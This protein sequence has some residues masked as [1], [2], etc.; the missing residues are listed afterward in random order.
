MSGITKKG[1]F[2]KLGRLAAGGKENASSSKAQSAS[3]SNPVTLLEEASISIA[4][5][6]PPMPPTQTSTKPAAALPKGTPSPPTTPQA[7]HRTPTLSQLTPPPSQPPTPQVIDDTCL[8]SSTTN[9]TK[10]TKKKILQPWVYVPVN[11]HEEVEELPKKR[12][13]KSKKVFDV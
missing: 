2:A 5:P 12:P 4:A 6:Q 7:L 13:R 11:D 1:P 3:K 8:A 9:C 10:G